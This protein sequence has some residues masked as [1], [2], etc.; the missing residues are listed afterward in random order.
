MAEPVNTSGS[1]AAKR[2][3]SSLESPYFRIY[4][5]GVLGQMAAMV[6]GQVAGPLLIYRLTGSA[7]LLGTMSL[8]SAV[9]MIIMSFLGGAVADRVSKKHIVL[10]CYTG[11]LII[12]TMLGV[13]LQVG[14]LSQEKAGSYW[15]LLAATFIQG[16]L[17]GLM[18]PALQAIVPEII[19]KDRIMNAAAFTNLG[20]NVMGLVIPIITGIIIDKYGFHVVYFGSAGLYVYATVFMLFIPRSRAISVPGKIL[21]NIHDGFKYIRSNSI[22]WAV[23]IFSTVMVALS[24]PIQQLLPIFTDDI[25]KV[26]ATWLGTL[27]GAS[28]AGALAGSLII[29]ALP[30]RRR[31]LL[32]IVS[33]IVAGLTLALFAFSTR[34]D[35][36]LAMM[37]LIGLASTFRA[38]ISS[39]LLLTY[40]GPEFM[41]RVMSLFTIQFGLAALCAFMAGIITDFVG[42]EKVV[43]VM[44]VSLLIISILT[45]IFDRSTRRLA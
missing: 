21:S 38:T 30:N 18:M 26:S 28:G 33:G 25:L 15:I 37:I 22:V 34:L 41:G 44:A 29:T 39:A 6:A 2:M 43:G 31:G 45:L 7:A 12:I 19:S 1:N 4:F 9:P 8:L 27:V 14:L 20:M 5:F 11:F 40:T 16:S 23:L 10:F 42:V 13:T 35:F 3:I 17:N 24:M 36:S 32:L